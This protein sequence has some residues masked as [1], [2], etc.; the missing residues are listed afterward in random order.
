MLKALRLPFVS[1]HYRLR[2]GT[3]YV[4]KSD[5]IDSLQ[6]NSIDSIQSKGELSVRVFGTAI[7]S[8]LDRQSSLMFVPDTTAV[9]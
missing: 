1:K 2:T 8:D 3:D 4:L 6:S 5:R 7:T 9:I